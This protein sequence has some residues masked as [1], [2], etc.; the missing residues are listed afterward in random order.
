ML[1]VLHPPVVLLQFFY[2]LL[3]FLC[4]LAKSQ[5]R[6]FGAEAVVDGVVSHVAAE[7][8]LD[9]RIGPVSQQSLDLLFRPAACVDV[10]L[11]N[12]RLHKLSI[13]K[14]AILSSK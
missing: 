9:D 2:F 4:R 5:R 1:A 10:C 3:A 13:H 11:N 12:T 14:S 6:Q 7:L 8:L